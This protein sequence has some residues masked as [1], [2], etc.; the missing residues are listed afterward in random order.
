LALLWL[1][2][3]KLFD[4]LILADGQL[5][6]QEHEKFTEIFKSKESDRHKQLKNKIGKLLHKVAG[7]DKASIAIDNKFI[8]RGNE[9]RRPDVYCE[10]YDKELVFEIQLSDLSLG[11]ILSRYEFYRKHGIYLIWILDNFDI[12][13]Q[14]TLERDIKYLTKYENF[15]KLD[16]NAETLRFECE[17][18]FLFLTAYN[19]LLTKWLK[20]SVSLSQINFDNEIH[21]IYYYNFGDNKANMEIE[22]RKRIVRQRLS[23]AKTKA[24]NII[25]AIRELRQRKSQNF[26]SVLMQIFELDEYELQELNSTLGFINKLK[27]KKLP[28]IHWLS[29]ATQDDVAFIEFIL[30]CDKIELDVNETDKDGKTAFQAVYENKDIYNYI[31]IISLFKRGYK[32]TENDKAFFSTLENIERDRKND[33]IIYNF[34]NNLSNR[35]W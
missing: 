3:I 10:Y 9:K 11:Y 2:F 16:E 33:I 22:Q 32:L 12:H 25:E 35:T 5:S 29:T 7:V 19:K 34:C 15:F 27:T 17:Y 23:D 8:I 4:L 26:S 20:K 28:I 31:P 14:G 6:S 18:K 1:Y 24:N 21:Q 30:N 13:N